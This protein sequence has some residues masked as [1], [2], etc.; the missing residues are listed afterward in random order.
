LSHRQIAVVP[1][2][3][4]LSDGWDRNRHF[5]H[6]AAAFTLFFSLSNPGESAV[7]FAVA[8]AV[9]FAFALLVVIP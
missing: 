5:G 3:R 1:I 8:V 4:A 6:E 2:H 7:A 9:A